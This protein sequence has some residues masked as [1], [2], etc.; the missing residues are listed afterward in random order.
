MAFSGAKRGTL[1]VLEEERAVE[2]DGWMYPLGSTSG[3]STT[4]KREQV[5]QELH[6]THTG[7]AKIKSLARSYVWWPNIIADLE[8]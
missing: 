5:L 2:C 3:G 8:A 6:E 7:I 4:R 1:A